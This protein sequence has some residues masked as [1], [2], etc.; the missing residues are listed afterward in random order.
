MLPVSFDT[1]FDPISDNRDTHALVLNTISLV[2]VGRRVAAAHETAN[3][4]PGKGDW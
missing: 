2:D 3:L 1:R 4:G